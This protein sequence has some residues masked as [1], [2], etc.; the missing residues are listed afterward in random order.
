MTTPSL[1]EGSRF[2]R[3][4]AGALLVP[5]AG[6]WLLRHRAALPYALAPGLALLFGLVM[7]ASAAAHWSDDLLGLLWRRPEAGTGARIAWNLL[8]VTLSFVATFATGIAAA[9]V[10]PAPINDALGLMVERTEVGDAEE[11]A[12]FGRLVAELSNSL[13]SAVLRLLRFGLGHLVLLPL[14]LVPGVNAAYPALAFAW[15][16][17]WQAEAT[18]DG[19]MARHLFPHADVRAAWKRLGPAGWGLG[20]ALALFSLIPLA[21]LLLI[22]VAVVAGT[23]A[24]VEMRRAG[25]VPKAPGRAVSTV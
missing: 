2:S 13:R 5:R 9:N 11:G 3:F 14:L 7:G 15:S 24:F 4:R 6:L 8:C 22:S 19:A 17:R 16:A 12:G 21:N 10:L 1:L 20:A 18:L 23:L 25:A